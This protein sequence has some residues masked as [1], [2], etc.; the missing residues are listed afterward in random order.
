MKTLIALGIALMLLLAACE[1]A[2]DEGSS[3]EEVRLERILEQRE[4]ELTE[5]QTRAEDLEEELAARE[6]RIRQL[7]SILDTEPDQGDLISLPHIGEF[8]WDCND[9]RR[10]RATFA[11]DLSS[12]DVGYSIG[13]QVQAP[14]QV[15][16]RHELRGPFAAA[17]VTQDWTVTYH[18]KPGA[19]SVGVSVL[20][21]VRQG[22][23][24]IRNVTMER[25]EAPN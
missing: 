9:E 25:T 22:M 12:V 14:R 3:Q 7:R 1:G 17:G 15:N 6:V 20:P 16:P 18:H 24:F 19:I 2:S 11:P 21:A 13:D 10:F 4:G 23:C 8:S 5:V